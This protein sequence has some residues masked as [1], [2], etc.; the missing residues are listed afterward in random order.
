[1]VQSQRRRAA[2]ATQGLVLP[3][4]I[5]EFSR[6]MRSLSRLG[7]PPGWVSVVFWLWEIVQRVQT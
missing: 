4:L 2:I 3:T 5:Q 6:K 1:M 7:Q